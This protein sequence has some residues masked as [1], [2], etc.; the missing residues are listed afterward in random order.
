M[1]F[2]VGLY[3]AIFI[4]VVGM[5]YKV[6]SW[7]RYSF[8]PAD[9]EISA[10][11]RFVAAVKGIF[12]T[13]FSKKI[14]IIIKVFVL[15]V[16]LQI[17]VLRENFSRWLMHMLIFW[18]FLLL[19]L[20]HALES[21]IS[22]LLFTDYYSTVNPF[23]FLRD[24]FALMAAFGIG[25]AVFRRFILKVPRTSTN[26]MDYYAITIVAFILI[27]GIF[28]EGFKITSYTAF[29]QMQEDYA[30]LEDKD[31]IQALESYWV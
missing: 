31:E 11:K 7:F 25:I 26:A 13:V 8:D 4:F 21:L 9:G 28:L 23:L 30:G 16:L 29:V 20:M 3:V 27:S 22:Q 24:L 12:L 1:M 15:D 17:R 14:G 19:V 6:S 10:I 18:G 2:L 5:I